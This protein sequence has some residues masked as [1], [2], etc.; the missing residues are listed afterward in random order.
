MISRI[1][2]RFSARKKAEQSAEHYRN[3]IRKA[4]KIGGQLFGPVPKGHRREFF[5]LD[6][7]TWVWHEEWT[8]EYGR[9]RTV[10]TRYDVRPSG[11]L[12]AQDGQPYQRLSREEA[13]NFHKAV[14]MYCSRVKSELYGI[15]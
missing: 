1:L 7:Y 9:Q 8:D 3:V 4:A 11:T 6:P 14:K 15:N 12:K 10:T 2:P 5:C 13:H